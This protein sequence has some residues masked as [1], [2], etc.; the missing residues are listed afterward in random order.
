[1]AFNIVENAGIYELAVGLI[2]EVH[3]EEFAATGRVIHYPDLVAR[4][5]DLTKSSLGN[6]DIDLHAFVPLEIDH[7][8]LGKTMTAISHVGLKPE[9]IRE[10][11]AACEVTD[12]GPKLTLLSILTQ[13]DR[14]IP[15][16]DEG[17]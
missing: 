14:M 8:I 3:P 11:T 9:R 10:I 16:A 13:E 1:M 17:A 15:L 5:H 4:A 6:R 2:S 7:Y 12:T